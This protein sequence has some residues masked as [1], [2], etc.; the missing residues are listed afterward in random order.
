MKKLTLLFLPVFILLSCS[1]SS[2][3]ELPEPIPA[4]TEMI[5]NVVIQQDSIHFTLVNGTPTPCY[6]FNSVKI[7]NSND[8]VNVKVYVQNLTN[9]PCITVLSSIETEITVPVK[10]G[11]T[12]LFKFW[13]FENATL[14]TVITIP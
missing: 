4:D 11:N 10:S 9:D 1:T 2:N 13:K 14:D 7:E 12:Y 6:G 5:K 3:D 8:E